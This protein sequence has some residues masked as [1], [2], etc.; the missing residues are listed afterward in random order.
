MSGRLDRAQTRAR[1]LTKV[2]LDPSMMNTMMKKQL[3]NMVPM[4]IIGGLINW[5]FSGF[6]LS[7][8][9]SIL[10]RCPQLT[11]GVLVQSVYPFP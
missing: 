5:V 10:L 11:L 1:A 9:A 8:H 7:T 4:V 2:L 6:V 3:I